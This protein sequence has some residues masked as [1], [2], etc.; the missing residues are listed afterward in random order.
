MTDLKQAADQALHGATVDVLGSKVV[1]VPEVMDRFKKLA[2]DISTDFESVET[3]YDKLT[4]Q[5]VPFVRE[6][7]TGHWDEIKDQLRND[8]GKVPPESIGLLI[9]ACIEAAGQKN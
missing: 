8:E 7:F 2:D 3:F 4:N 6:M 9:N 5:T 1:V